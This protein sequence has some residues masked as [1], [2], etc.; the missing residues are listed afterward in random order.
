M[1][2]FMLYL[3][4]FITFELY[5]ATPT[6]TLDSNGDYITKN[7]ENITAARNATVT[8][9]C[10]T[11]IGNKIQW[12][13]MSVANN[14]EGKLLKEIVDSNVFELT[15]V[16][17]E[18][19]GIYAC[20][21]NESPLKRYNVTVFESPY[22]PRKMYQSKL[23]PSGNRLKLTCRAR[24]FPQ[25]NVVWY[26]DNQSPPKR[27]MGDIKINDWILTFNDSRVEDSG[28]YTCLV[29]NVVGCINFTFTVDVFKRFLGKPV[30]ITKLE[31]TTVSEG[32][33]LTMKCEFASDLHPYIRWVR[34]R[35][36]TGLIIVQR[37]DTSYTEPEVLRIFN[38]TLEDEGWYACFI[39]NALGTTTSKAYLHVKY[40]EPSKEP[41][42]P[43]QR[44][45]NLLF[46]LLQ[47]QK[48]DPILNL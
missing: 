30:L 12:R 14:P 19:N 36:E 15:S 28:N 20:F 2:L 47:F 48:T 45:H 43:K 38:A 10:R 9:Q 25:P 17:P 24:G 16:K 21:V 6:G 29:C 40:K 22:F 5:T 3:F 41:Q 33:N 27:E 42:N 7:L 37:S 26:K 31:N 18:H 35:N 34:F 46:K 11:K 4:C 39:A 23:T 1:G 44:L 13:L 8:L 32:A